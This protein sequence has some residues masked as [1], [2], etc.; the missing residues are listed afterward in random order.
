MPYPNKAYVFSPTIAFVPH[1]RSMT[2]WVRVHPCVLLV[3]CPDL[4]CAADVGQ[5][6][7]NKN[8]DSVT[9][10]HYR[11][12]RSVVPGNKLATPSIVTLPKGWRK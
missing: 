7:R 11:R 8:G 1:P 5:L 3:D 2:T 4:D 6:C 9:Y 12:R 10:T